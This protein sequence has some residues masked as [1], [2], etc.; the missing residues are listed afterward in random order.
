MIHSTFAQVA[1]A[2]NFLASFFGRGQ[3]FEAVFGPKK[4]TTNGDVPHWDVTF[5]VL[6]FCPENGLHFWDPQIRDT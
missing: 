6:V 1:S 5:S 2:L 4:Q 3:I